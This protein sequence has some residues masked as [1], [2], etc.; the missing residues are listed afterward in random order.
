MASGRFAIYIDGERLPNPVQ[1]RLAE[2]ELREADNAKSTMRLRF[3]LAQKAEGS[4][5]V[6]DDDVFEAGMELSLELSSPGGTPQRVFTGYLAYL[7]PHFE[8][9]E[10]NAY[11]DV[12]A[13]DAAMVLDA[14]ER[15][16]SYPDSSDS[17]AAE[18]IL[19]R[20]G[21][22]IEADDSGVRWTEDDRLLIQRD[23]D[24]DFLL[25]LA[26]RNGYVVYFEPDSASG[27]PRCRFG[28]A[29]LDDEPQADLIIIR[30]NNNLNW[31]DFQI[32]HDQ[33]IRRI[34]AGINPVSKQIVR[35]DTNSEA[36]V[37]G[38]SLYVE[39]SEQG[40]IRAGA[41]AVQR[42]VRSPVPDDSAINATAAGLSA[43]DH[44]V[45]EARGELDPTLYRGLL[46]AHRNVLIK[47]VGDRLTG[48]YYVHSVRTVQKE[49]TLTQSFVAVSNA[50]GRSGNEAFGQSAEEE[51]AT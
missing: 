10:S 9:I 3:T 1:S 31:I 23:T 42:F 5:A 4:F 7:R 8:G 16:T 46:R 25:R 41:E 29:K 14:E 36:E 45:I 11:L 43:E 48:V 13:F 12:L 40:L 34:A 20:Y 22:D 44:M 26:R 35:A 28:A 30:D 15:V 50:L 37:T 32:A 39:E 27:S 21:I 2:L 51:P 24:W 33:P 49:G 19:G 6:L 18:I 17:E 38:E 47:G